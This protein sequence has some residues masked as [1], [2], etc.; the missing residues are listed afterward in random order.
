MDP[1]AYHS[2]VSKYP[3]LLDKPNP[4]A[5]ARLEEFAS[6]HPRATAPRRLQLNL[7]TGSQFKELAQNYITR[8]LTKGI[9][10]LFAD[11]KAL[12]LDKEKQQVIEDI[13]DN[14]RS[15]YTP[16]TPRHDVDPT[17]Y[18]WILY[19]L[20]QHYSYLSQHSKAL[21]LLNLALEHTPTLPELPMLKGRIL[22]RLGDY[23][24]AARAMNDARSLDGQ[25]RF[26]NTKCGKYLLRAGMVDDAIGIFGMFTKVSPAYYLRPALC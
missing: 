21:T 3:T 11:L 16:T 2:R 6:T 13:V 15:E 18:L 14:L 20:S 17:I 12:Y 8:G 1:N 10:S 25:D 4:E 22:K 23:V 26:L 9:P 24:G 5:V 19:F 7:A